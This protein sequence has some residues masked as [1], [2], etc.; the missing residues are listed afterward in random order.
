[1][2]IKESGEGKRIEIEISKDYIKKSYQEGHYVEAIILTHYIIEVWMNMTFVTVVRLFNP[3]GLG[4]VERMEVRRKRKGKLSLYPISNYKFLTIANILLDMDIYNAKVFSKLEKFNTYRNTVIHKL[5]EKLPNKKELDEY[6]KLGIE[7]WEETWKIEEK[8]NK[9][10]F[11]S[12]RKITEKKSP[13]GGN[14]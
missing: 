10:Y 7:L 1:M 8:Y 11:N 12:I 14:S 2:K 5:F 9:A 13:L 6:F 3:F 4:Y